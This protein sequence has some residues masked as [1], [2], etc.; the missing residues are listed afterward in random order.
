MKKFAKKS[1][2]IAVIMMAFGGMTNMAH[3]SK[4]V[5]SKNIS[6]DRHVNAGSA[7]EVVFEATPNEIIAGELIADA[8]V[9]HIVARDTTP[10]DTWDIVPTGKSVGG[11]MVTADGKTAK[12]HATK[13]QWKTSVGGES[14]WELKSTGD[15]DDT[16]YLA[17]GLTVEPGL[18]QF[19]GK[20]DEYAN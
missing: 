18:Y 1:L 9:F 19:T 8:P 15:L 2:A 3:A 12:L 4:L 6:A 14:K 5:A 20:V 16:F 13:A 17:K 7:L 10:H 11:L